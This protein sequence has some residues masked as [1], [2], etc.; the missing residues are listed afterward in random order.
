MGNTE[1]KIKETVSPVESF[2]HENF[3]RRSRYTLVFIF[4]VAGF[5]AITII[6]INSGNVEIPI[7]RI[8]HILF[9]GQGDEI[10]RA[11]CRERV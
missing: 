1:I 8:V 9:T 11:S 3:R 6:N 2:H 10:G 5:F 7:S 4:L